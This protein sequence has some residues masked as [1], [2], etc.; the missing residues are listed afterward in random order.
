MEECVV[1]LK[2]VHQISPALWL[3]VWHVIRYLGRIFKLP[4]GRLGLGGLIEVHVVVD[5]IHYTLWREREDSI[6]M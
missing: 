6:Y 2:A 3:Q 4:Y 1:L 5:V